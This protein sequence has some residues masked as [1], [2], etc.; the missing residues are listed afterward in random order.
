[1]IDEELDRFK[2]LDLR[3][4]A[5]SMGY[6]VSGRESSRN[7]TVMRKDR[8]KIIIS[9]KPDGHYTYWSPRDESDRGTVID[10]LQ[11]RKGLT[12]GAVRKEMRTWSKLPS[13]PLPCLPVL[14]AM[15]KDVESVRMRYAAM[16]AA[17]QHPYLENE[18]G[19]PVEVLQHAR[20]AGKV[21]IDRR[22]A[23][24]FGHVDADGEMC[25]YEL[26]NRY[27]D[28]RTFTGYAPG[29]RKGAFISNAFPSDRS[30]VITESGIDCLSH[31]ALFNDPSTRY[32]SIGGKPTLG[33]RSI[34]QSAMLAMPGGSV[35]VAATDA[36]D[37]LVSI[38]LVSID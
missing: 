11:R 27:P 20:F 38:L 21:K 28:R 18:R 22:G 23:A 7:S 25:G 8:D 10:F 14:T 34:I 3:Q 13:P 24:V 36:D 1:M 15:K 31:F 17:G 6:A 30:L 9:R 33:Q 4:I 35:I 12:L 2:Q 26:K 5:V 37:N 32:V 16:P 19:I 29:G